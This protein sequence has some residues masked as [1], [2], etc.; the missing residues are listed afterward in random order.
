[1]SEPAGQSSGEDLS[2]QVEMAKKRLEEAAAAASTAEKRVAAEIEALE[3]DLEK[4]RA[5]ASEALQALR[6][7]HEEE[8]RR[9]RE[10][11][12]R[13]VAEAE[14]R[15]AEIETQTEA[16]EKRI[17]EAEKHAAAA[18]ASIDDERARAREAAAAWLRGQAEAIRREA[19]QR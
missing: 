11:K 2:A 13:V 12:D 3:T 17:E 9:E 14:G 4:E 6:L 16:A 5:R 19:G 1:M 10:A 15:L 18:E 7:A 8:L